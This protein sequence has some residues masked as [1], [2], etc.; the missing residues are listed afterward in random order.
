MVRI[1][2]STNDKWNAVENT[3]IIKQKIICSV[4]SLHLEDRVLYCKLLR[5]LMS[6]NEFCT[7]NH[8]SLV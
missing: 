1:I 8:Q 3:E 5:G 6:R 4:L 7:L 2:R